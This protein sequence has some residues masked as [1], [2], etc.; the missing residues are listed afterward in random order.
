MSAGDTG[1]DALWT[2]ENQTPSVESYF[3]AHQGEFYVEGVKSAYPYRGF[4]WEHEFEE[5]ENIDPSEGYHRFEGRGSGCWVLCEDEIE[6]SLTADLLAAADLLGGAGE[7]GGIHGPPGGFGIDQQGVWVGLLDGGVGVEVH[8]G[9]DEYTN[10]PEGWQ[11]TTIRGALALRCL[12][13]FLGF[14]WINGKLE[15][16]VAIP[17]QEEVKKLVEDLLTTNDS[18]SNQTHNEI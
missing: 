15:S 17:E 14:D 9:Q 10:A 16:E 3:D 18:K 12:L 7:A 8:I 2:H 4:E 6:N 13:Q 5:L 11:R 1:P